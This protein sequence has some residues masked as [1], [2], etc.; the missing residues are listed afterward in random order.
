MPELPAQK[1]IRYE[2]QLNLAANDA[3]LLSSELPMANYFE[4]CAKVCNDSLLA[5]NWVKVELLGRLNKNDLPIERS[6]ISAE[7]LG[8]LLLRIKDATIS[9]KIAKEIF[10]ALWNGRA[11]AVDSYIET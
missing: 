9:G 7:M 1:R 6:P 8:Q 11:Q 2:T 4:A 10:N 3:W 5:A